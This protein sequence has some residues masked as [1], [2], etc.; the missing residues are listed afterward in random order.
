MRGKYL[1]SFF[2]VVNFKW[3]GKE[4]FFYESHGTGCGG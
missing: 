2:I 4:K 1:I 3:E